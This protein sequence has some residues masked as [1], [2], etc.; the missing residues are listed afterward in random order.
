MNAYMEQIDHLE[1]RCN[2]RSNAERY[3]YV[4]FTREILIRYF[5]VRHNRTISGTKELL[6][7]MIL[8]EKFSVVTDYSAEFYRNQ[9][10][11]LEQL[12]NT[13]QESI[14]DSNEPSIITVY[15][16]SIVD[17]ID[18]L[19]DDE[20]MEGVPVAKKINS[21]DPYI[22]IASKVSFIYTV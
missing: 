12:Y 7:D 15:P 22:P 16:N 11:L 8:T 6:I 10:S 13:I 2:T 4:N 14:R 9:N 21:F 18:V 5:K 20:F 3:L 17:I 19:N 1:E